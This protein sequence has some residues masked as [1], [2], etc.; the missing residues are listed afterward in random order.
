MPD[1]VQ[2]NVTSLPYT[3]FELAE[4]YYT[5]VQERLH[6]AEKALESARVAYAVVGGNA[7]MAWVAQADEAAIRPTC[8]VDLL[9]NRSEFD[10]A[11]VALEEAGFLYR[12]VASIDMFL[13][14]PEGK[15]RDAL[16]ILWSGEKVKPTDPVAAPALS[17]VVQAP[18]RFMVVT[19]QA[20]VRMKL[21]NFR[22]KD[23]VHLQ[24]FLSTPLIDA[25]WV[26]QFTEPLSE[27]LQYVIDHPED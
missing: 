18:G 7:V 9:L 4:G 15:A 27:R 14:G 17:E 8:N 5:K 26:S 11:K 13:D 12:H 3:V 16:H 21:T 6:R 1:L 19:L 22:H 2:G 20:L 10:A 24:D 25:N 23:I